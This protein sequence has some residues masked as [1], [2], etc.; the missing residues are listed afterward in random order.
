MSESEDKLS[1]VIRPASYQHLC[2]KNQRDVVFDKLKCKKTPKQ[3]KGVQWKASEV[4]MRPAFQTA[5]DSDEA[6]SW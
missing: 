4:N 2:I 5:E 1:T 6:N 3:L